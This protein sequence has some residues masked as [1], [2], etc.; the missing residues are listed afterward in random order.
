[1]DKNKCPISKTQFENRK[2]FEKKNS[3]SLNT[4]LNIYIFLFKEY[5]K[6]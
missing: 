2:I 5:Y 1:M 6:E 3:G 4:F